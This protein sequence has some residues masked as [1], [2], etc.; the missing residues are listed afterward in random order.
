LKKSIPQLNELTLCLNE[1]GF[2]L[3]G[4]PSIFNG[5]LDVLLFKMVRFGTFGMSDVDAIN[6]LS[7]ENSA[8]SVCLFVLAHRLAVIYDSLDAFICQKCLKKDFQ[9]SETQELLE[10]L[11]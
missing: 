8:L 6:D 2:K 7:Y 10:F 1:H 5:K 11:K 4:E 9:R 3:F